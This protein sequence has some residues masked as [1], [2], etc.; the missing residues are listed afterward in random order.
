MKK[1][2]VFLVTLTMAFSLSACNKQIMDTT[3][4]YDRAILYLP[5]GTIVEGEVESWTDYEDGDQIQ[6]KID[7]KVYLVH[8]MNV[9]LISE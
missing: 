2:F 9:A 7:G 1:V 8:S 6:I 5:D 3:W 4:S